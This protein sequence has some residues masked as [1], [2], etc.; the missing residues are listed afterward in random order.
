MRDRF[1]LSSVFVCHAN[2]NLPNFLCKVIDL[3][4]TQSQINRNHLEYPLKCSCYILLKL[5]YIQNE[6]M[7]QFTM[8]WNSIEIV[9]KR[10][11]IVFVSEKGNENYKIL[12]AKGFN[13]NCPTEIYPIETAKTCKGEMWGFSSQLKGFVLL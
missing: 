4:T 13:S 5:V 1:V 10:H 12:F 11:D 9:G 8:Y 2:I 7:L 3:C 6:C